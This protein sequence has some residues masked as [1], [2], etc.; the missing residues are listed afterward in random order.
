MRKAM[1]LSP[2]TKAAM[3]AMRKAAD[4]F[5]K[6]LQEMTE[7]AN[8]SR[9]LVEVKMAEKA[10]SARSLHEMR[11]AS[12]PARRLLEMEMAEKAHS[13]RSLQEMMDAADPR[14]PK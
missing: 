6:H 13:A 14:K 3:E 9:R 1:D 5:G 8:P 7:A 11:S 4:L 2:S 10:H 12:D